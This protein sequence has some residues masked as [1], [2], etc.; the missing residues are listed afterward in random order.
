M[1]LRSLVALSLYRLSS[2][3]NDEIDRLQLSLRS[4]SRDC[5]Y[6]IQYNGDEQVQSELV[7]IEYGKMMSIT[8][9][10]A[11]GVGEE[12]DEETRDG[13][14]YIYLFLRELHEGRNWQPSFQPLPLLARKTEEQIEEEGA[15]EEIDAQ[16]N[17]NGYY[18]RIKNES[19]WAKA[20]ALNRFSHRG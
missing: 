20:A 11:G 8:F 5:L 18:G 7:N 9:S 4:R 12:H 19:K 10:A 6:W 1:L 14:Y 16:M 3:L 13:L 2:C 15:N 17:N